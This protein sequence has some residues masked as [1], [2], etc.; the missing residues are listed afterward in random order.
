MILNNMAWGVTGHNFDCIDKET[1]DAITYDLGDDFLSEAD[2]ESIVKTLYYEDYQEQ[3]ELRVRYTI[4][5]FVFKIYSLAKNDENLRKQIESHKR[6]AIG[7]LS[8]QTLSKPKG[9]AFKDLSLKLQR[10]IVSA[11]REVLFVSHDTAHE[12][13][14]T[15]LYTYDPNTEEIS[16]GI[17]LFLIALTAMLG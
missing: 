14:E 4:P 15:L 10:E 6:T 3:D 17:L 7:R 1:R 13:A 5:D 12:I 16:F 11:L 8:I 9:Q 2:I